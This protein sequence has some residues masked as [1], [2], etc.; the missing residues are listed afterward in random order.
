MKK[1]LFLLLIAISWLPVS[2]QVATNFTCNDCSG[3]LHNLFSE[4]DAGK[5]IVLDWVM[6]CG[7]C[8]APSQTAHN[9]VQG[10]QSTNPN[11]VLF[12]MVDDYANTSCSSL[13]GWA[14]SIGIPQS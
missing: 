5:V 3:N 14:N 10:F 1:L 11:Q 2:A 8:T 12:Y 7:G 9:I 6:P 4:L 13:N